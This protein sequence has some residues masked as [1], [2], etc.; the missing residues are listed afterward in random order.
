[1]REN[2]REHRIGGSARPADG[3]DL[4]EIIV[5]FV[6]SG[7]VKPA[8]R[9]LRMATKLD[10]YRESARMMIEPWLVG[11]PCLAWLRAGYR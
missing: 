4:R 1:V 5:S 9:P 11:E 6:R 3:S 10:R 7:S 8:L 2:R